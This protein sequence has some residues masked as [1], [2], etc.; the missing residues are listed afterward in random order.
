MNLRDYPEIEMG[1]PL[2]V[3]VTM[4]DPVPPPPPQ[5]PP[6]PPSP[7]P[8]PPPKDDEPIGLRR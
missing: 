1:E 3:V 4:D 6:G 2:P 7:A 5:G 8:K